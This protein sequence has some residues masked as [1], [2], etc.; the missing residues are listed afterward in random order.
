M[1]AK[2]IFLADETERTMVALAIGNHWASLIKQTVP[3]A[4]ML[5]EKLQNRR[6]QNPKE[7][8]EVTLEH[9]KEITY[10]A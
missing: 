1:F 8:L 9:C 3:K 4:M 7:L 2:A 5:W 6:P 10:V